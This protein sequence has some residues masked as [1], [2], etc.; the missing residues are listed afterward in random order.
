[1][2]SLFK[3][4]FTFESGSFEE[5]YGADRISSGNISIRI[6]CTTAANI[7]NFQI[8]GNNQNLRILNDFY[9]NIDESHFFQDEDGTWVEYNALLSST[10]TNPLTPSAC[11]IFMNKGAISCV[12]FFMPFP[13]RIIEYY[14]KQAAVIKTHN[15]GV[16]INGVK[17]AT[18][19]IGINRGTFADSP[20]DIGGHY[21][22]P[23]PNL[24]G[25]AAILWALATNPCPCPQGWRVPT[26]EEFKSLVDAGSVWTIRNGIGGRLFGA[27]PNQIFLPAAGLR[28]PENEFLV[29][30]MFD[31][32]GEKG[33]YWS[34][35]P[36]SE[37][38]S[39]YLYFNFN[40]Q[41]VIAGVGNSNTAGFSIRCV[42]E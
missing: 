7:V 15:E 17:W 34:G 32:I 16:I 33:R 38:R 26:N 30:G 21:Q 6:V 27:A 10:N 19:N 28:F 22:F 41:K 37:S 25:G 3:K 39:L 40:S 20:E 11:R 24:V 42:A 8:L 9:F 12:R 13:N 1:M 14:P 31:G 18:R 4:P 35:T 29:G 5:W 23:K 2:N 36:I